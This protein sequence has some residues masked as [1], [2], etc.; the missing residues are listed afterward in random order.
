MFE[1]C[2]QNPQMMMQLM[3]AD[4]RFMDIFKELTG[5]DLM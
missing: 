5:I 4:P 3:Q 1:M 2:K